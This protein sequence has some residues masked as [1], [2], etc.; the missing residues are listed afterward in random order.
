[1]PKQS[2]NDIAELVAPVLKDVLRL[3]KFSMV[4]LEVSRVECTRSGD[5]PVEFARLTELRSGD[6]LFVTMQI[7][8]GKRTFDIVALY[9][10]LQDDLKENYFKA[11]ASDEF[12]GERPSDAELSEAHR[13]ILNIVLK[14]LLAASLGASRDYPEKYPEFVIGFKRWFKSAVYDLLIKYR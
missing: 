9:E 14:R 5:R 2:G 3:L 10:L 8:D 11:Y 1:M 6:H 4:S 7:L 13:Q 12:H